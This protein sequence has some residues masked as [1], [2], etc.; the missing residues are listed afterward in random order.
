MNGEAFANIISYSEGLESNSTGDLYFGVSDMDQSM[1]DIK[2][3]NF[4][5]L[6]MSEFQTDYCAKN[7]WD[8]E[9]PRCARLTFSGSFSKVKKDA[10]EYKSALANLFKTHPSMKTW[11]QMPSHD[12]YL[13]KLTITNIWLIDFFGGAATV[14]VTAYYAGHDGTF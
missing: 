12:F 11:F 4:V 7:N 1:V 14:P 9:D 10:P 2:S 8:A 5:S 3:H 13:A 6:S